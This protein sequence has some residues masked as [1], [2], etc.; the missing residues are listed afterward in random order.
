MALRETRQAARR[1]MPFTV[2]GGQNERSPAPAGAEEVRNGVPGATDI[3]ALRDGELQRLLSDNAHLNE[4]IFALL[5]MLEQQRP[6]QQAHNP[7]PSAS[8]ADHDAIVR[9]V[10]TALEAE[11]RP[12]LDV[13]LHLLE[14]L[15]AAP[16]DRQTSTPPRDAGII[17]LDAPRAHEESLASVRS[18]DP[19]WP[20]PPLRKTP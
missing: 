15:R 13:L 8:K 12:V 20:P 6:H 3:A 2:V 9:E 7:T 4:R 18:G 10:R 1:A 16:L 11:L 19:Q 5:E 14:T 17:D